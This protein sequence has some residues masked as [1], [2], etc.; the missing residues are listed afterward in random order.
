M[1]RGQWTLTYLGS[2]PVVGELPQSVME[3]V[4][5]AVVHPFVHP[6]VDSGAGRPSAAH[7]GLEVIG[8]LVWDDRESESSLL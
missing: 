1:V 8:V 7:W 5:S 4:V 6:A 2:R 3:A